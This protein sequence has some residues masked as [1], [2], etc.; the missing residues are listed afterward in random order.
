MKGLYHGCRAGSNHF[1]DGSTA[2]FISAVY[3]LESSVWNMEKFN[4]I[5]GQIW[6]DNTSKL[7]EL[8]LAEQ[9]KV[10]GLLGAELL[11][12]SLCNSETQ[13]IL[14]SWNNHATFFIDIALICLLNNNMNLENHIKTEK[15]FNSIFYVK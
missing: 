11:Y 4:Q 13:E 5:E 3:L 15:S 2:L 14:A 6:S 12:N 9:I 10:I 1:S 8:C 7:A